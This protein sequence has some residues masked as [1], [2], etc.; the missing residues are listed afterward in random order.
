[1]RS[2]T[3]VRTAALVSQIG[4]Q[5]KRTASRSSRAR[6][7][8]TVTG[9]RYAQARIS[10]PSLDARRRSVAMSDQQAPRVGYRAALASRELRAIVGGQLVS[11][12]G[13][14]IAAVAL[15]ILVYRRTD[16]P[17]LSSLT[18]ALGFVPYLLGGGLLSGIVDRVRPRRL[19]VRFDLAAA[20]LAA[21]MALPGLPIAALFA[22]LLAIGTLSSVEGGARASL[23]RA[24][25][26]ADAYV[27][28]RSLQRVS[29]QLAQIAGNAAGGLL[30]LVLTPRGALLVNAASF[31]FSAAT[32]RLGIADHPNTGQR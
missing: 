10:R 23:V 19:V 26:A 14:S 4:E 24:S 13:T 15:T 1:M 28:A 2:S 16:S 18:F 3:K 9:G 29:A 32:A 27:P 11:V 31:V 21:A 5:A 8:N 30:L 17:L 25:V 22:L 12:A 7:A 20:V 6:I